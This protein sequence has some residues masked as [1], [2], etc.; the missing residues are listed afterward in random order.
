MQDG[1]WV[2]QF[3][4]NDDAPVYANKSIIGDRNVAINLGSSR[5]ADSVDAPAAAL[6][7]TTRDTQS[8]KSVPTSC[9]NDADDGLGHSPRPCFPIAAGEA[10][11]RCRWNR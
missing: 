1:A 9:T 6:L 11:A 10:A 7:S 3:S 4:T 5:T 2:P 8:D